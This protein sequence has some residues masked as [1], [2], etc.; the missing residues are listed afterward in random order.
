MILLSSNLNL[1]SL[2]ENTRNLILST[3]EKIVLQEIHKQGFYS[4]RHS[5]DLEVIEVKNPPRLGRRESEPHSYQITN[6]FDILTTN[7]PENRTFWDLHHYFNVEGDVIDIQFDISYFRNLK[8]PY[9]ISSYRAEKY[10]NRVPDM[11]INILSKSTY[12]KDIGETLEICERLKIP[13]Y[14]VFSTFNF[15]IN[16]YKPPFLNVYILQEDELYKKYILRKE[17]FNEKGELIKENLIDLS[18]KLP[19]KVGIKKTTKVYED[20]T[21]IYDLVLLNS[22]T[23][24]IYKSEKEILKERAENAEERAKNAEERAKN[25]EERAKNAEE[26]AKKEKEKADKLEQIIKE[27]RININL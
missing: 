10:N 19:F 15:S 7:F 11:A 6:L 21:R 18:E 8:V 24:E 5:Q 1:E 13:I 9:S 14:I 20:G 4:T 12:N 17:S 23:L 22:K 16:T 27:M 2:D 3:I 26:R 25:A